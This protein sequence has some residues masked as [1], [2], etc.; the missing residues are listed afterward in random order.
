MSEFAPE[1]PQTQDQ[2]QADLGSESMG[3][4]MARYTIHIPVY[5]S[6][7]RELAHVLKAV[8]EALTKAGFNGRTVIRKAQGDWQ[9]YDTEEMDLVM[10]D[11]PDDPSHLQTLMTIAQG[12]KAL[13]NHPSVYLT[14][15]P[16]ETYLV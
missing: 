1:A 16:I 11:A 7:K 3:A 2:S 6:D 12:V 13:A 5:S 15:Q 14:K 4:P 8:R 9:N 10:V